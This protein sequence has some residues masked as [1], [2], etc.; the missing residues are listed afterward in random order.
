MNP[1]KYWIAVI[2]FLTGFSNFAYSDT[3]EEFLLGHGISQSSELI[4]F[5]TDLDR[6]NVSE[7][8][9]TEESWRNGAAGN[10]WQLFLFDGKAYTTSGHIVSMRTD[11]LASYTSAEK[12]ESKPLQLV[13]F[14]PSGMEHGVLVLVSIQENRPL[15]KNLGDVSEMGN[16]NEVL[17]EYFH[18]DKLLKPVGITAFNLKDRVNQLEMALHGQQEPSKG[19]SVVEVTPTPVVEEVSEVIEE[20]AIP[21]PVTKENAEGSIVEP[22]EEYPTEK[23]SKWWLFLVGIIIVISGIVL[24]RRKK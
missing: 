9:L 12:D 4:F 19:I 24:L 2:G 3:L 11:A 22:V 13:T 15:E 1:L 18:K 8:W 20:V 7:I 17:Q 5:E 23:S 14:H 10:M 21:E 6:N 16:K